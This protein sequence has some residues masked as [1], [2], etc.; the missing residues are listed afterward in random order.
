MIATGAD[1]EAKLSDLTNFGGIR[2]V[3]TQFV[4]HSPI[5]FFALTTYVPL[6]V[7]CVFS[8]INEYVLSSRFDLTTIRPLSISSCKESLFL[9]LQI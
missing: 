9:L 8:I 3:R 2:I 4:V 1:D 7:A 5:G 6:S